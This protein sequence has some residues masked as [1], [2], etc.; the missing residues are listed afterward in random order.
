MCLLFR[1]HAVYLLFESKYPGDKLDIK[2][3][4]YLIAKATSQ[5]NNRPMK[6]RH[7]LFPIMRNQPP[8]NHLPPRSL[9]PNLLHTSRRHSLCI[10]NGPGVIRTAGPPRACQHMR[11]IGAHLPDKLHPRRP[12]RGVLGSG[13]LVL[14]GGSNEE[15]EC[16]LEGGGGEEESD[17]GFA[18]WGLDIRGH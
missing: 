3:L 2:Y 8:T 12:P 15:L 5:P 7:P 9:K 1:V 13:A 18:R 6:N 4:F 17:P 11:P 10:S 14:G 16:S